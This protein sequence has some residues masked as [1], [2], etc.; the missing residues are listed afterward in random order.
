MLLRDVRV[1]ELVL[2]E[3]ADLVAR[4]FLADRLEHG[5]VGDV[6]PRHLVVH[7]LLGVLVELGALSLVGEFGC[8]VDVLL[9]LG[10]APFRNVVGI[11][12]ALGI[13]AEQ[14]TEEVI[15]IAA[16]AYGPRRP[17]FLPATCSRTKIHR[18]GGA[19]V[20]SAH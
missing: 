11:R 3:R 19:F 1:L 2:A 5:G 17:T 10:I 9:E 20:H 6:Q 4:D 15:R 14:R 8:L 7:D 12:L 13:A 18:A 16:D